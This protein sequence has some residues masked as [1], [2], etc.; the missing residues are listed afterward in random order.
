MRAISQK[1]QR[2]TS[3]GVFD[4]CVTSQGRKGIPPV[5]RLHEGYAFNSR[6]DVCYVITTAD[7][8]KLKTV[9]FA[10]VHHLRTEYPIKHTIVAM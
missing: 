4:K 1:S 5:L 6:K 3:K 2:V 9:S 7:Y 8:A 10:I